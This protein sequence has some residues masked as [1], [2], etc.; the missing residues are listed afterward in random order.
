MKI[1]G[2]D[3]DK[4]HAALVAVIENKGDLSS[5]YKEHGLSYKRFCW[6]LFYAS[7]FR[8]GDGVG[9]TGDVNIAGCNDSHIETAIKASLNKQGINSY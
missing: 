3:F 6:D 2:N 8:I 7:K 9:M 1:R 5:K 4:L